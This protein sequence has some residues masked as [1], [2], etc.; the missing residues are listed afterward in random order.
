MPAPPQQQETLAAPAPAV[1]SLHNGTAERLD[2][3]QS[4]I[5]ESAAV[6][7][8]L[9][10]AVAS[11]A[12]EA[13]AQRHATRY[14]VERLEKTEPRVAASDYWKA[15]S[16][17]DLSASLARMEASLMEL[18]DR[19]V[20]I[21][22]SSFPAMPMHRAIGALLPAAP[23]PAAREF[24][25]EGVDPI[26][27]A[28]C[29]Y[30]A[31]PSAAPVFT[32]DN[33]PY[34]IPAVDPSPRTS[35]DACVGTSP[36]EFADA[37]VDASSQKSFTIS[38]PLPRR[39]SGTGIVG[40]RESDLLSGGDLQ[41][42]SQSLSTMGLCAFGLELHSRFPPSPC[43]MEPLA[44]ASWTPGDDESSESS[45]GELAVN[46]LIVDSVLQY[47]SSPAHA[48]AP[49]S[50]RGISYSPRTPRRSLAPHEVSAPSQSV[51]D[52]RPSCTSMSI[53]PTIRPASP[54]PLNSPRTPV[55]SSAHKQRLRAESASLQGTASSVRLSNIPPNPSS[56]PRASSSTAM[57]S[58]MTLS[59]LS[60]IPSTS[61][62]SP[63]ASISTSHK[64]PLPRNLFSTQHHPP[65]RSSPAYS[66]LSAL[67]PLPSPSGS[68]AQDGQGPQSQQRTHARSPSVISVHSSAPTPPFEFISMPLL[69]RQTP[70]T[71]PR[72]R[73]KTDQVIGGSGSKGKGGR[74]RKRDLHRGTGSSSK[75]SKKAKNE[76]SFREWPKITIA[77]ER[78]F[79]QCDNC[80]AWYHVKCVGMKAGDPCLQ[81]DDEYYCPPCHRSDVHRI[82][83]QDEYDGGVTSCRRPDCPHR[84][85]GPGEYFVDKI[86]GRGPH[87]QARPPN[88][89]LEDRYLWLVKWDGAKFQTLCL[90]LRPITFGCDSYEVCAATWQLAEAFEDCASYVAE[91]EEA[92]REEGLDLTNAD[93]IVLLREAVPVWS[94]PA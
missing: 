55:S 87:G 34:G 54:T 82:R 77:S 64:I 2:K 37:A 78:A 91:F 30:S 5:D 44:P 65:A 12:R 81:T 76:H 36:R 48:S 21:C 73:R 28:R 46:D 69:N 27:P 68:A 50:L 31:D 70:E 66:T 41:S 92:A 32:R 61:N 47:K 16:H 22:T 8:N 17:A 80:K 49:S 6:L 33:E 71:H 10:E 85:K 42:P 25:D 90:S 75:R 18:K 7:R 63:S 24:V 29:G 40:C 38:L 9:S 23:P 60:S 4:A 79:V 88:A 39:Q 35:V 20:H 45:L 56:Q 11:L 14:L 15:T 53:S 19:P 83:R 59:D 94:C 1:G 57:I 13:E 89:P 51:E 74:P 3:M 86:I 43:V 52:P 72:K 67:T 93:A 58:P 62:G 26:I 84:G